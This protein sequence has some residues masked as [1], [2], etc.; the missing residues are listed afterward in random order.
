LLIRLRRPVS[1]LVA[2]FRSAWA[3]L[4]VLALPTRLR[5]FWLFRLMEVASF[6]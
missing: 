4:L 1:C 2:R 3:F 5:A 6:A